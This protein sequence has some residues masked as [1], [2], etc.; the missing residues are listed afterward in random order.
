MPQVEERKT[1]LGANLRHLRLVKSM[2]LAQVAQLAEC[3]EG[4]LSKIENGKA[5]PSLNLL[6]R[7][8]TAL[9][10][11]VGDFFAAVD[12]TQSLVMRVEDRP[13]LPPEPFRHMQGLKIR[14]LGP[15]FSG[16]LMQSRLFELEPGARSLQDVRHSGEILVHVL[17]GS[18]A[19]T[20]DATRSE[21]RAGDSAQFRAE[22]AH[23][24]E[25]SHEG[26]TEVIWITTPPTD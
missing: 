6:L 25:N 4:L 2:R 18:C 21:L 5:T 22:Q 20:I 13:E 8:A 26:L 10:A 12:P 9:D 17:S 15:Y 16:Q 23:R 1:A 14:R 24:L 19:L 3:S 11:D 7:L